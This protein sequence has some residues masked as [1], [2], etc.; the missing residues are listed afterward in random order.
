MTQTYAYTHTIYMHYMTSEEITL[1]KSYFL[2]EIHKTGNVSTPH[3]QHSYKNGEKP[4]GAH[5]VKIIGWGEES[6]NGKKI[7]YWLMANS[8]GERWGDNGEC[9]IERCLQKTKRIKFC[10]GHFKMVRGKNNCGIEQNVTAG[11]L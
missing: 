6:H 7:L 4:V 5:A 2:V 9:I 3:F 1:R 11:L 10:L 8:W